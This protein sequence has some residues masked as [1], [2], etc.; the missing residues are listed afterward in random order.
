MG[1]AAC[2]ARPARLP[3]GNVGAGTGAAI[4]RATRPHAARMMKGGLGTASVMVGDLV[5]GA[6]VVVNCLG[7]VIDPATG[8]TLAGT[9]NE[10]RDGFA[11]A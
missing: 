8:E 6:I 4:G 5:V 1:Y 3:Q 7:N 10:T 2:H 9:L 11:G